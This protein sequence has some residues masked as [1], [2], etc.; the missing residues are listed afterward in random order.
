MAH[1][2]ISFEVRDSRHSPHIRAKLEGMGAARLLESLWVLTSPKSAPQIRDE[3]Q[4]MIDLDDERRA[5]LVGNL[6]VVLCSHTNP[7]PVMN[8]GTLYN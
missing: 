3:L 1:Y 8:T 5:A 6:L 4:K 7:T 2:A